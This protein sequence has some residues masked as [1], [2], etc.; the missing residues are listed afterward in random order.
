MSAPSQPAPPQILP[1]EQDW[2]KVRLLAAAF[3][4]S[5]LVL[6]LIAYVLSRSPLRPAQA[7]DGATL[8]TS[9]HLFV[10]VAVLCFLLSVAARRVMLSRARRPASPDRRGAALPFR[11]Y[12]LVVVL[13][14]AFADAASVLGLV[15]FLLGGAFHDAALL[16]AIAFVGHVGAFP[17]RW[18]FEDLNA[19]LPGNDG[20]VDND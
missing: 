20:N 18:I 9:F 17:R 12:L 11:R 8:R 15:Y 1:S 4:A 7:L 3:V 13:S 16:F 10:V 6:A 2:L 5:T 14:N 19:E